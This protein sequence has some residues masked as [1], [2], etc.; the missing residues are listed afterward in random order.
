MYQFDENTKRILCFKSQKVIR[1]Y[2]LELRLV[3]CLYI[4]QNYGE[5]QLF[6]SWEEIRIQNKR[7]RISYFYA[8]LVEATL[9]PRD[10][11][12][13]DFVE[14]C[15]KIIVTQDDKVQL[16]FADKKLKIL[17]KKSS[18][19][20]DNSLLRIEGDP[21]VSFN[22]FLLILAKI[23]LFLCKNAAERKTEYCV[24]LEKFFSET[25]LLRNNDFVET[26]QFPFQTNSKFHSKLDS[27]TKIAQ[28]G[29]K[30]NPS[31][32]KK[33][34]DRKLDLSTQYKSAEV[35]IETEYINKDS[36]LAILSPFFSDSKSKE[37]N[38]VAICLPSF[39]LTE[40]QLTEK[41]KTIGVQIPILKT[42]AVA[43]RTIVNRINKKEKVLKY[44]NEPQKPATRNWEHLLNFRRKLWNDQNYTEMIHKKINES[45]LIPE[46]LY[47]SFEQPDFNGN[48]ECQCQYNSFQ[49][50]LKKGDFGLANY[51][52]LE[53]SNILKATN[54]W[55]T[56]IEFFIF[57]MKG[58]MKEGLGEY[59]AAM[60]NFAKGISCLEK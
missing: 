53:L 5:Q 15:G 42:R 44:Q 29:A 13:E 51:S 21:G 33:L 38:K 35:E 3:F 30:E 49:L 31:F 10:L 50:S 48:F 37:F 11:N 4:K 52:L 46:M 58:F 45:D 59:H 40:K 7:L 19:E 25:L 6:L 32:T 9:I 18:L 23:G 17:S 47:L 22:E 36:A 54:Q 26:S 56:N 27:L 57:N 60:A 43:S 16:F 12:I 41:T 20:I 39:S 24:I 2:L 34:N 1:E 14:I 28:I 8:F 55:N